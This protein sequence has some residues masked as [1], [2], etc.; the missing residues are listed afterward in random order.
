MAV[1]RAPQPGYFDQFPDAPAASP[2]P[3]GPP[4][5]AAGSVP[6]GLGARFEQLGATNTPGTYTPGAPAQPNIPGVDPSL[7]N[8]QTGGVDPAEWARLTAGLPPITGDGDLRGLNEL[9]DRL[10]T[11]GYQVS[12]GPV[13]AQGRS[14]SLEINGQ[15]VRISDSG[16]NYIYRPDTAASPAWESGSGSSGG[17][18]DGVGIGDFG[19]LLRPFGKTFSA[20]TAA[21]AEATPGYQFERSQGLNAID[22][23]A[24]AKG[25]LLTGGNQKDRADYANGLASTNYQQT[26]QNA[27][28]DYMTELGV[29]RDQRDS[30][31]DKLN[32]VAGRG[33]SAAQAATQ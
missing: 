31:F 29:F 7:Q 3:S 24:A 18:G 14:D 4:P 32:T 6:V 30:T 33:T 23:G 28:S 15:L 9:T 27:L 26:Y 2:A 25:T 8:H 16:G 12:P 22:T 19:S 1:G 10:K 5:V 21:Q 17:G 20:P 13:D 11:E